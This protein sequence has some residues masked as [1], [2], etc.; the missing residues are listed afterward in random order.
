M[1]LLRPITIAQVPCAAATQSIHIPGAPATHSRALARP[2]LA[3]ALGIHLHLL[4]GDRAMRATFR[5]T[6]T[7]PPWPTPWERPARCEKN[8]PLTDRRAT[9]RGA[10]RARSRR[11]GPDQER[12]ARNR[13][14]TPR[15]VL[16]E[17]R[18]RRSR[19]GV[20]RR[21]G[22]ELP[23]GAATGE[24]TRIAAKRQ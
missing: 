20:K 24:A 17:S 12:R 18:G 6:G 2:S 5:H 16:P 3:P 23:P 21:P 7:W 14:P 8:A 9:R 13:R 10:T 11:A 1:R 19:P 15:P 22:W 4:P